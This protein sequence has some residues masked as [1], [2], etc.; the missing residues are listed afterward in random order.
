MA[1]GS[2]LSIAVLGA[3]VDFPALEGVTLARP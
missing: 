2:V 3:G 1:M